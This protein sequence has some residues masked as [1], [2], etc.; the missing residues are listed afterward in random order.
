MT[1][2]P[3]SASIAVL[4]FVNRS[5]DPENEY[6]SD[7]ITEE[8]INALTKI[9]GLK[10]TARTSA[11]AYKNKP[12]DIRK[13][14][15]QLG[16]ANLL[17]GSVRKSGNKVRI[18]AQLVNAEDGAHLWVHRFDRQLADIFEL[19]DEISLLIADQIREHYGH[20]EMQDHLVQAPT[21]NIRA[22]DLYL[23]ARHNHLK[24]DSEGITNAIQY[25][26]D[27]IAID[28]NFALPYFGISYCFA[29]RASFSGMPGLLDTAEHYLQ[30]GFELDQHSDLGY[31]SQGTLLFWGRWDFKGGA[32]AY[33]KAL[34]INP[35][36]TEAEEGLTELYTA[37]GYFDLAEEHARHILTL[38]PLSPNHHFTLANIRY[39]TGDYE[40]AL[41]AAEAAL[42]IDPGFTHAVGLKQL[43]LI[44]LNRPKALEAFLQ[45]NRL[46]ECPEKCRAL[47][48][49][50]H[51]QIAKSK[52]ARL[53]QTPKSERDIYLFTWDLFLQI[54]SGDTASAL[55]H[56]QGMTSR[57]L[58]QYVNFAHLPLLKP[59]HSTPV[60]QQLLQEVLAPN[61]LPPATEGDKTEPAGSRS[62]IDEA[63]IPA[64]LTQ[65]QQLMET[66]GAYQNAD[67]SLRRLAER[68]NLTAN[69]LSW[70]LNEHIGQN[71]N[72]YINAFRLKQFQRLA[73]DPANSHLTLLGL[74]YESGFNSKTVFNAYFKKSTGMTPRA[75]VKKQQQA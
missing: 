61:S 39:L 45:S 16:V 64:L 1:A 44:L 52:V 28:P 18:T 5:A 14:G 9:K 6:F 11:F 73:L 60:F 31:F 2:Q 66:E 35:S 57:H 37:I 55:D 32:A 38:N 75:W 22:Y 50:L 36:N 4:P 7:G 20:F 65:L 24:W 17:E 29:M 68:L 71:F 34:S 3:I 26:Q 13:I 67:L 62:L 74:A 27:C 19:Q 8:I 25:Y 41:A 47:Y 30:R 59:L 49:L 33:L 63:E 56:L 12:A 70:L 46:V 54:H 43:C 53:I 21:Q 69:K 42:Q 10:V 58:G 48:Q 40:A 51:G 15:Q 23:K 72:A